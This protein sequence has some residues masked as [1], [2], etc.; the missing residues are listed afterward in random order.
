M[1]VTGLQQVYL[2]VLLPWIIS[3][4]CFSALLTFFF[5]FPSPLGHAI[6]C[7]HT[8]MGS[9]NFFPL[10]LTSHLSKFILFFSYSFSIVYIGF[11]FHQTP[12]PFKT[13]GSFFLD[14]EGRVVCCSLH[15]SDVAQYLFCICW[16]IQK[17]HYF[18]V[19]LLSELLKI[20]SSI[21]QLTVVWGIWVA[22]HFRVLQTLA[23][24]LENVKGV[25][26]I[27]ITFRS[28]YCSWI[29]S[30]LGRGRVMGA[31]ENGAK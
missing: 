20:S 1:T 22:W 13:P 15:Y 8:F 26:F 24:T 25:V 14:M 9:P 3:A 28:H 21:F 5:L 19:C 16:D 10:A 6:P 7:L 18:L 4:S 11:K 30:Y 27:L 31:V 12:V 29:F 23:W 17:H 2:S